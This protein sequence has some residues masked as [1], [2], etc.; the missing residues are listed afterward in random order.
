[1]VTI[2]FQRK[3][4]RT[5]IKIMLPTNFEFDRLFIVFDGARFLYMYTCTNVCDGY[6]VSKI[7]TSS[8]LKP[9]ISALDHHDTNYV[10]AKFNMAAVGHLE[11]SIFVSCPIFRC[12]LITLMLLILVCTSHF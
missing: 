6:N 10:T 4:T 3:I 5:C 11:K 9:G 8:G 1:M 12:R 2:V 7:L